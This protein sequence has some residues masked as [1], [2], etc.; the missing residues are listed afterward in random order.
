MT[1]LTTLDAKLDALT[2]QVGALAAHQR[3]RDELFDEFTP[4]L[5]EALGV[6]G[7]RLAELESRGYFAFGKAM[8]EVLD[9]IVT[10]YSPED[11]KELAG[12][13]VSILD[14]V[15]AMTQPQMLK[16]AGDLSDAAKHAADLP[17]VGI[18]GALRASQDV[19]AQRGMAVMLEVLRRL[20]HGAEK[21]DRR[22]RLQ[23]QLA[24]RRARPSA[25]TGAASAAPRVPNTAP[26]PVPKV[27][28]TTPPATEVTAEPPPP[29]ASGP[30]RIGTRFVVDGVEFT[31]EG[32]LVDSTRWS[33]ELAE[34][35]A[36]SIGVELTPQH[37]ALIEFA[38]KDYAETGASPNIR[39]LTRGAGISTKEIYGLFPKA[40]G[41]CTALVAGLPKPVG[42]I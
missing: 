23:A 4:I 8:L 27:V 14:A 7:G 19:D 29:Q 33:A 39:R 20:G 11:V 10:G 9:H 1:D 13:V 17:P 36:A 24:S 42:C 31:P 34:G 21:L 5:R 35:L 37:W 18:L 3:R 28:P 22:A 15:R 26:N 32:F 38:R 6:G 2:T 40:P 12:A 16:M 25:D 41:K 30:A